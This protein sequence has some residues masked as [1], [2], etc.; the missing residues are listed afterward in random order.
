MTETGKRKFTL[1]QYVLKNFFTQSYKK[2][3]QPVSM[4]NSLCICKNWP[5]FTE[6]LPVK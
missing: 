3:W 1:S 2:I 5:N 4:L 6:E